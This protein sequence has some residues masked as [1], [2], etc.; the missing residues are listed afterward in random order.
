MMA[1]TVRNHPADNVAIALGDIA[2]GERVDVA[3][4]SLTAIELI[5][6]GHKIALQPVKASDAITRYGY[7]IAYAT[8]DIEKGSLVHEHNVSPCDT[9][10]TVSSSNELTP[11]FS[12]DTHDL[13][14]Q[15]YLRPSGD[16]GT[17]NEIWVISLT[18]AVDFLAN[19]IAQQLNKMSGNDYDG[20]WAIPALD[21]S[22]LPDP[23]LFLFLKSLIMHPN[24]GAVLV[25][26]LRPID[27][28]K[29]APEK[30]KNGRLK[31][32]TVQASGN[33]LED[34]TSLARSMLDLI[35]HDKRTAQ[36]IAKLSL[37]VKCGATD[38]L[39]GVTANPLLGYI[40]D[41]VV[42]AGGN[43]L[44]TELP[45]L[46]E[47][48]DILRS[49]A[50]SA[51]VADDL[52]T[53][54]DRYEDQFGKYDLPTPGRPNEGNIAG[55]VS[56]LMEKALGAVQKSGTS[57]LNAV[58]DYGRRHMDAGFQIVEAPGTDEISTSAL[59][60][61]GANLVMFS[62]GTGT[63]LGSFAPVMKVSSTSKLSHR[64][65]HWIDFDAG[66]MVDSNQHEQIVVS[67]LSRL[68]DIASGESEKSSGQRVMSFWKRSPTL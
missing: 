33:E 34:G 46:Y 9:V 31:M 1:R 6:A 32:L 40:S 30:V 4:G 21:S 25:V 39:S 7:T 16:A 60:L 67:C 15:G 61:A 35:S 65:P 42:N 62:T 3:G 38:G 43:V 53:I 8:S 51:S 49:R 68:L 19:Q 18:G 14:W 20:S 22:P 55:G 63:P 24:A 36:L 11:S 48:Q 12:Q 41:I 50:A 5:P 44:M 28:D 23:S 45:E 26:G 52:K 13:D 10:E 37:G 17:R 57:P 59:V 47:A 27:L 58:I 2:A 66:P 29:L 54:F 64:K 56:T